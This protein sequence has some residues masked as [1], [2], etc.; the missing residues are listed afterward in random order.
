MSIKTIINDPHKQLDYFSHKMYAK[1]WIIQR[2]RFGFGLYSKALVNLFL[3]SRFLVNLQKNKK[4]LEVGIGDGFPYADTFDKMGY[5]VYGIDISPYFVSMVKKQLPNV[6][7]SL[8]DAHNLPFPDN[9]FHGVYCIRSSWYFHDLEKAIN[10]MIRVVM[11]N[12]IVMFDI[13][14]ANN[15]IN[16]KRMKKILRRVKKPLI[17]LVFLGYIK[18]IVK[19]FLRPI[20][21]YPCDW[22]I[23]S[24]KLITSSYT[25]PEYVN[26]FLN[27][28]NDVEYS[29]FSEND[30]QNPLKIQKTAK[31]ESSSFRLVYLIRLN[32]RC[33]CNS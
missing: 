3:D 31:F 11:R 23:N 33:Q 19:L 22:N 29:I 28:R 24:L 1:N 20:K 27:N 30:L 9:F 16:R 15:P 13:R 6:I 5:S 26:T 12:G 18:N 10:E 32:S 7:V 14:N 25:D 8:G 4:I 2:K 21:F 17:F